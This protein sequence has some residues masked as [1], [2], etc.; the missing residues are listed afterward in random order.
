VP[1]MGLLYLFEL[2]LLGFGIWKILNLNKKLAFFVIGWILLVPVGSALT[3]DDIPNLQ[4]TLIVFPAFSIIVAL[5]F[6]WLKEK[7]KQKV[8]KDN[9]VKF[10][11][12][13]L[14]V[15]AFYNF[16]Y[17]MHQYYVQQIVHRPWY[18]QEGYK[19]LVTEINKY[20]PDYKKVIVTNAQVNPAILLLFYNQYNPAKI[21][22]V[23]EANKGTNY[24]DTSFS[25]YQITQEPCPVRAGISVDIKTGITYPYLT[26]EK[27]ILYVDDGTCKISTDKIKIL[28]QIRRWDST[29]VF[30]LVTLK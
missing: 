27:G 21:Q 13:L 4:R 25:K 9:V 11:Y 29:L 2:P 15:I 1:G 28:S 5:G 24:G 16:A 20:S 7:I 30:Q 23:I 12:L 18:R 26:G 22:K 17:Y 6:I 10:L 14:L 8:K 3:F 19:Q